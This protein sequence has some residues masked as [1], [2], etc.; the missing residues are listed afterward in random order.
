MCSSDLID[1]H[2][3]EHAAPGAAG[4]LFP[5][6][7]DPTR[8]IP[9]RTWAAHFTT[10]VKAAGLEDVKPHDLRHSGA[11]LAAGTGATVRELM[12]RLGHTSPT[13]AMRYQ[14]AAKERDRAIADRLG[15]ALGGG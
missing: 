6:A 10:A 14:H 4:F 12:Q 11:T 7:Q 2:L 3:A 8:P 9:Y 13:I 5:S 15:E 1:A